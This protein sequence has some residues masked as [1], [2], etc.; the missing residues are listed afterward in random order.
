MKKRKTRRRKD[1][2][3]IIVLNEENKFE[4]VHVPNHLA[5]DY[6]DEFDITIV[7]TKES[8]YDFLLHHNSLKV[9]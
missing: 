6:I 3:N 7:H 1:H 5:D 2:M 4:T 9:K 8:V